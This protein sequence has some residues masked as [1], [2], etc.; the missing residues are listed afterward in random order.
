[1]PDIY[2]LLASDLLFPEERIQSNSNFPQIDVEKFTN[3]KFIQRVVVSV[4]LSISFQYLY[5]YIIFK[6]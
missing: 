4:Y 2:S 6:N 5:M 3:V 1:M